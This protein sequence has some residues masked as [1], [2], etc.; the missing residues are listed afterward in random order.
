[1]HAMSCIVRQDGL[2]MT[3]TKPIYFRFGPLFALGDLH[4]YFVIGD[5][6]GNLGTNVVRTPA[7]NK[8]TDA[9]LEFDLND[10]GAFDYQL[11]L[12]VA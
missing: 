8:D 5:Q 9:L 12:C 4:L 1:M 6:I 10:D 3:T 2:D 11:I 7:L